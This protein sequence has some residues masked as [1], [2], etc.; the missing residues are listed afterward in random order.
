MAS[1]AARG[2]GIGRGRGFGVPKVQT[3]P[4]ETTDEQKG[5]SSDKAAE[6]FDLAKLLSDL[7]EAT[8]DDKEGK[9]SKYISSSDS[10]TKIKQVVDHLCQRTIKDSEFAPLAAKVANKLCSEESCGNAFRGC[11]L[12]STQENFKNRESIRGKSTREWIGLVSFICQLFNHLRTGEAPLKPLAGAVQQTMSE[13]LKEENS[14]GQKEEEED[15]IDCFYQQFKTVGQLLESVDQ[16][17]VDDLVGQMRDTILAGKTT[18]KTRCLLLE[19]LELRACQ[20]KISSDL[21][22]YYSDMLADILA[23]DA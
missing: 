13:L 18:A 7:S 14:A 2:R 23:K 10:S 20:W 12:K 4:G 8:L 15:E 16:G 22:R 5:S 21:E 1:V 11:L 9:L 19:L 3:K 6:E 17:K